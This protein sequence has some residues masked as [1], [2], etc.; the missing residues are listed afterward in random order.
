[1]QGVTKLLALPREELAIE[2][3]ERVFAPKGH[4]TSFMFAVYRGLSL[5]KKTLR[6]RLIS[7]YD[8]LCRHTT[9]AGA[10]LVR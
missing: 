9:T 2:I 5:E 3:I 4:A 6:C 1:M 8:N 7:E 10:T